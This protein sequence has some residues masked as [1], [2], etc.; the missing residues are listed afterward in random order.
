VW[1]A[2]E[3]AIRGVLQNVTLAD[4]AG[5]ERALFEIEAPQR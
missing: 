4:L 2:V 5:G 1:S 3:S